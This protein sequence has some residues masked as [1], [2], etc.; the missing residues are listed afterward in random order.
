MQFKLILLLLT[1][2]FSSFIPIEE[3]KELDALFV[4]T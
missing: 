2:V 3:L 1:G 4:M